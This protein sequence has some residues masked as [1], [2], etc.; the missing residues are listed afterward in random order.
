MESAY[1]RQGESG[2]HL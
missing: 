2:P 1:M